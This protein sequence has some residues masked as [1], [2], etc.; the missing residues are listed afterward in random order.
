M[1]KETWIFPQW[2]PRASKKFLDGFQKQVWAMSNKL[3][4]SCQEILGRLPRN[5]WTVSKG[6][7]GVSNKLLHGCQEILGRL[8][9]KLGQFPRNSWAVS[10][11]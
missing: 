8:P 6:K 4:H 9:K 2:S 7:L 3:L 5:P 1:F 11:S 10:K